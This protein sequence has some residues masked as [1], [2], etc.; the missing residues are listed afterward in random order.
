MATTCD[1][2]VARARRCERRSDTGQNGT[3]DGAR[4][5]TGEVRATLHWALAVRGMAHRRSLMEAEDRLISTSESPAVVV[6]AA[7]DQL[8]P[9]SI[10]RR[11]GSGRG[12]APTT[13][14]ASTS[15]S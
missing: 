15:G 13:I 12:A 1:G 7:C 9:P 3:W 4:G 6:L 11:R 10:T 5:A 14:S 8:K 2:G